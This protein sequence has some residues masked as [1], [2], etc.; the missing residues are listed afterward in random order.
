MTPA[1]NLHILEEKFTQL[2]ESAYFEPAFKEFANRT[3]S[4]AQHV[5]ANLNYYPEDIV[6]GFEQNPW[7][8]FQFVSGSRSNDAPHETQYV[9][10]KVLKDWVSGDALVSSAALNFFEFYVNLA[11]LW[12]FVEHALDKFDTG[13]YSPLMVQI[14]SPAAYKNRPVFC[15]PLLHEL[16]H[17]IDHHYKISELSVLT[18]LGP[19]PAGVTRAQWQNLNLRHRMEH[20]A[21]LFASCYCGDATNKSLMAIA[22]YNPAS[23]THPATDKRVRV[24]DDFLNGVNNPVVNAVQKSLNSRRQTELKTRFY[25]PDVSCFDDILTYRIK[26]ERELYGIFLAAWNYLHEQVENRSAPWIT[27]DA[28]SSTI[29][30]TVNDLTEKS[31]RNFELVE[32]W[33]GVVNH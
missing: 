33:N 11:D 17:F 16:G 2:S 21:D 4:A 20:F 7:N 14:G 26:D 6:R 27:E 29:E 24:V 1:L 31:I 3:V 25:L 12:D 23:L 13:G 28:T 15:I 19:A 5:I 8:V 30:R 32:R 18:D 22:P 9:L 10:R